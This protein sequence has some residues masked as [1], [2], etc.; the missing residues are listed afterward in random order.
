MNVDHFPE[1]KRCLFSILFCEKQLEG[2]LRG[3]LA[4]WRL[5]PVVTDTEHVMVN[6]A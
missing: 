5:S 6:V 2:G 4:E 3:G 1:E